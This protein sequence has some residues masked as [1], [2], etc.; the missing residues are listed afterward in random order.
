[1]RKIVLLLFFLYSFTFLSAQTCEPITQKFMSF[2]QKSEFD[3]C[4]QY[5]D[6]SLSNKFSAEMM[7]EMWGGM[8]RFLGDF[9]SYSDFSFEKTDTTEINTVR[10]YFEKTK[11]DLYLTYNQSRKMIGVFF[12]PAK[13]KAAYIEPSYCNASKFYESKLAVKTGTYSLP[14]VLCIPN[15]IEYPPIAILITGSGPNDKDETYGPNKPLKDIAVGLASQGIASYRYDKRTLIYGKEFV[16]QPTKNGI[17]EEVIEDAL[18]AIKLIKKNSQFSKSK[19]IIV[20][21]SLGAMCAPLIAKKSKSVNAIILLAGNARP[22]EDLLLEQYHYIFSLDSM[23]VE[24]KKEIDKL[25]IQVKTVKDAKLLKLAKAEDLPL[26]LPSFY[27]QSLKSYNQT[28]VVKKIKQPI[29]ILQGERDYQVTMTD[30]N[31]WEQ[32]LNYNPKNKFISYPTLNHL[33]MSGQGK[34]TPNEYDTPNNV[35]GQVI[36]DIVAWIK[37]Q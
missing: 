22:L 34:S 4:Q 18:S 27:W 36:L 15:N 37:S 17:Y 14:G 3:S 6:T 13:N 32:T 31:L 24:E 19:I 9:K 29:L 28:E 23:D 30:F 35:L 16:Q 11:L 1:M 25:N 33:F 26:G 8:S 20:G 12:K 2:M 21:H 5:F 7:E 10:C